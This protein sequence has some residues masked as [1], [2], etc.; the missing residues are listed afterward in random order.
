MEKMHEIVTAMQQYYRRI[1]G[2]QGKLWFQQLT[3]KK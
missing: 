3:A 1:Q 2:F